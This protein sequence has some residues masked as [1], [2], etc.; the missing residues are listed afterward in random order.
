M[1]LVNAGRVGLR[2]PDGRLL[3]Y[4][5]ARN[6]ALKLNSL[7]VYRSQICRLADWAYRWVSMGASA[8]DAIQIT[9]LLDS[10]NAF[11]AQCYVLV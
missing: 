11:V 1:T 9:R 8:F 6:T 10:E 3:D 2:M 4:Q 5:I 7:I